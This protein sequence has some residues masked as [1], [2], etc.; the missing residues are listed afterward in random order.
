MVIIFSSKQNVLAL[1]NTELKTGRVAEPRLGS[2]W[3]FLS[4]NSLSDFYGLK[5]GLV[6]GNIVTFNSI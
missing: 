5:L 2:R 6:P 1:R 3:I 4:A